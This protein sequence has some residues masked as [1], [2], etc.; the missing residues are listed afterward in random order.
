MDE[1]LHKGAREIIERDKKR[2][3]DLQVLGIII[4]RIT[5]KELAN[6]S[7]AIEKLIQFIMTLTPSP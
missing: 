1:S 4:Y 6:R 3:E 2:T 5:N 7:R